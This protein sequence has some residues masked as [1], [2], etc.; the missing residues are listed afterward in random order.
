MTCATARAPTVITHKTLSMPEIKR[1][2][3]GTKKRKFIFVDYA[4]SRDRPIYRIVPLCCTPSLYRIPPLSCTPP[5]YR[6]FLCI[7]PLHT[8]Y[9][10]VYRI[11]PLNTPSIVYPPYLPNVPLC[12]LLHTEYTPV[13]SP[14]IPNIPLCIL[15]CRGMSRQLSLKSRTR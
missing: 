6:I 4:P 3:R 5:T 14:Y 9:A 10:P 7:F 11:Y 2:P 15:V 1:K 8:E 13:Y 12:I